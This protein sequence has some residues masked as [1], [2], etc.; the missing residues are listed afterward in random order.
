MFFLRK[1]E[2]MMCLFNK[3]RYGNISFAQSGEDLIVK[4]VLSRLGVSDFSYLDVGANDPCSINNTY[5]LYENGGSGVLVEPNVELCLKIRR[6]RPRDKVLNFGIGNIKGEASADYFTFENNV[7]NTFDEEDAERSK[8]DSVLKGVRKVAL[9]NI[10]D[11]IAEE[12]DAV[13]HFINLDTE[14]FDLGILSSF[15]FE[16]HM[17]LVFC[18]ETI[19]FSR[20][21]GIEEKEDRIIDLMLNRGYMVY[22][23]THINTIFVDKER[24]LSRYRK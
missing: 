1:I 8:K 10:N 15:D 6:Q 5:L 7:L 2:A 11:I 12:F 17:P 23:D 21:E 3:K 16:K 24:W 9:R 22:A 14:G 19:I 18:V 20:A 4:R 13:P